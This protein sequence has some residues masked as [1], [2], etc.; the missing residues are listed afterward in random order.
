MNI[1]HSQAPDK[2]VFMD[3]EEIRAELLLMEQDAS[4]NTRR[5]LIK[6]TASTIGF[7]PFRERHAT[8]LKDHPK[9][10]PKDYLSNLRT[11]LRIRL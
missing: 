8:Y 3:E 11:V 1:K 9:V 10:N 2:P 4:L 7:L 5:G 6:D